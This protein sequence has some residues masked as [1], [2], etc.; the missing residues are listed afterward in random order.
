MNDVVTVF[1]MP[2]ASSAVVIPVDHRLIGVVVLMEDW[3]VMR[4]ELLAS[5]EYGLWPAVKITEDGFRLIPGPWS[6]ARALWVHLR[7]IQQC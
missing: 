4:C 6:Y 5:K 1:P 2:I 3:N 7:K